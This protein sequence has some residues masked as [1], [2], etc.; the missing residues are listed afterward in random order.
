M[1][2]RYV[3][4]SFTSNS[5]FGKRK[6]DAEPEKIST[7]STAWSCYFVDNL[8]FPALVDHLGY[9]A[10]SNHLGGAVH[11]WDLGHAVFF[12]YLG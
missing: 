9:A 3:V 7:Y 5:C 8:D 1:F 11:V 10:V 6:R 2:L 4:H 12:V